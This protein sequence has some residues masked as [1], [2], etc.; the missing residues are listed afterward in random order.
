MI[1]GQY[2][3]VMAFTLISLFPI[4][5]N[6]EKKRQKKRVVYSAGDPSACYRDMFES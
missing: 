1:E 5:L 2:S 3:W 6:S 4:F